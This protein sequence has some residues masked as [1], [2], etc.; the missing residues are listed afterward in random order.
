MDNLATILDDG[1]PEAIEQPKE[2]AAEIVEEVEKV[3]DKA[4]AKPEKVEKE[5]KPEA[6]TAPEVKEPE[7]KSVPIQALMAERE[8]RQT[9]EGKLAE[10]TAQK[11]KEPLPDIFEDQAAYTKQFQDKIDTDRFNDRANQSEFYAQR[12]FGA[13]ALALKVEAFKELKAANPALEAQVY[14]AVSPYH[15]IA[16]IV[17]KHEKMEKMQNIDEYEKKTRAEIEVQV[18]AEIKAELEGK[19]TA[20][21][22]L[23][24]SIPTSLVDETSQGTVKQPTW[25]GPST[26]STL[27]ND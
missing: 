13:E 12:E 24:D 2:E 22:N 21:K 10:I 26:L 19:T 23:R 6:P 18:R 5:D 25:Q 16:D 17:S 3:E 9:L 27:F 14:N 4:E 15:E 20:D 7:S 11:A 1:E 8:K